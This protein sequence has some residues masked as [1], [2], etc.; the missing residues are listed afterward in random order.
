MKYNTFT[1]DPIIHNNKK[2]TKGQLLS[3]GVEALI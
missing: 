2:V 3:P 1:G